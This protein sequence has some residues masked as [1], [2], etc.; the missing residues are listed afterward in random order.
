MPSP[1]IFGERCRFGKTAPP[2]LRRQPPPRCPSTHL[3]CGGQEVTLLV[4]IGRDGQVEWASLLQGHPLLVGAAME[5]V[6]R[7]WR[8]EPFWI[9]GEPFLATVTVHVRYPGP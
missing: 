6:C 1:S 4:R 2:V 9:N 3:R 8:W 7:R 5:A